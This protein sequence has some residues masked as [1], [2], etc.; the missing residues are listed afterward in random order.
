M[1]FIAAYDIDERRVGKMLKIFR[2][3]LTWVQ[4][5]VFEGELTEAQYAKLKGEAEELM[6][7]ETDSVIFWNLRAEEYCDKET[8]GR[9][10]GTT[11][12]ML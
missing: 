10:R 2:R 1:Y 4:N 12:R 6:D 5:S 9:E 11:G 3:Y 8:L 7:P